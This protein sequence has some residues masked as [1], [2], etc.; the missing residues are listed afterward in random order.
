[1]CL[2]TK[3]AYTKH[4]YKICIAN[5]NRQEVYQSEKVLIHQ[6]PMVLKL[7]Y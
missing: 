7:M 3:Q 2:M 1:M 6:E 5:K 4:D